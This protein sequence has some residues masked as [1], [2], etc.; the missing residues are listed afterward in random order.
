VTSRRPFADVDLW[1]FFMS[2][3]AEVKFPSVVTKGLMRQLLR[4]RVPDPI[5]D[6]REKTVFN[7]SVRERIDYAELKRLL[8]SPSYPIAGVDYRAL[9]AKIDEGDLGVFEYTWAKDLA[10]THAFMDA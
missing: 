2:L 9:L 3:P 5:L 10:A 4:G 8:S 7:E 1:E 6:R